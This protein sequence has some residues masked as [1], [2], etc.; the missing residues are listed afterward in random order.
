MRIL[1]TITA[2]VE[3]AAGAAAALDHD[4]N[5]TVLWAIAAATAVGWAL[6]ETATATWKRRA[7]LES[8]RARGLADSLGTVLDD[9]ESQR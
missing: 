9:I 8:D 7:E 4:Y 6:A 1:L 3:I 2:L 5:R